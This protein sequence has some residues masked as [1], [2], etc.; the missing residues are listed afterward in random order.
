MK[1]KLKGGFM[2]TDTVLAVAAI[3][4]LLT[5]GEIGYKSAK[6]TAKNS[7]AKAETSQIMAAVSQYHY[8]MQ[9]YPATLEAL[10]AKS[11][12]GQYGPW[13]AEL[14]KDPWSNNKKAT[15]DYQYIVDTTN[16]RVAIFSVGANQSAESDTTAIKGDDVG[17]VGK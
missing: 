13:L 11:E 16:E 2:T 15:A 9:E 7:V 17:V 8:E 10:T 4:I 14:K 12:N 6:D 3:L 1:T 5:A